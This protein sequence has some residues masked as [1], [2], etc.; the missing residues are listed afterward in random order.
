[1]WTSSSPAIA[2]V[3][4]STGVVTGVSYGRVT[5]TAVSGR[6]PDLQIKYTLIV[7]SDGRCLVMPR[8]RTGTGEISA[9]LARISRVKEY[10]YREIESLQARG[11]ISASD[12]KKRR[13]IV[14]AAFDMYAFPWMTTSVQSYWKAANS[15]GGAKDFKPGIVYYG[16]P[17]ISSPWNNR[18]YNVSKA[19]SEKR[20]TDSGKAM[21][22]RDR[23]CILNTFVYKILCLLF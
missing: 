20:Y 21:C 14:S 23:T 1:M 8:R 9:N 2:A 3:D 22:I 12:A 13:S 5:I 19:L 4:A 6:N 16:M 7:L 11:V 17:Y 10:A 18:L 15:E